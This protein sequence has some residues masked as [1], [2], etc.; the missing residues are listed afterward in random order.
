[1]KPLLRDVGPAVVLFIVVV[2]LV[3]SCDPRPI[4]IPVDD[5]IGLLE[6]YR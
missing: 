6:V 1:M 5:R 2:S 4:E 3:L